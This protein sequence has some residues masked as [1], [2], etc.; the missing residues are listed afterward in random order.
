MGIPVSDELNSSF[1]KPKNEAFNTD[2][3]RDIFDIFFQFEEHIFAKL[4]LELHSLALNIWKYL[5]PIKYREIYNIV[6]V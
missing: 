1:L 2:F 3:T 4:L 6:F 5:L